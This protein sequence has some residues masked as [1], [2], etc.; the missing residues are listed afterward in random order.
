VVVWWGGGVGGVGG[1][2]GKRGKGE[3]WEKTDK[4]GNVSCFFG[5]A[6]VEGVVRISYCG[7]GKMKKWSVV[8]R[9]GHG[10][11]GFDGLSRIRLKNRDRRQ[12]E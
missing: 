9:I 5:R 6:V 2:E 8:G 10:W 7:G 1:G 11:D 4:I 12:Q 3:I